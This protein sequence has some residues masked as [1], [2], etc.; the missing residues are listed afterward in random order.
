[1]EIYKQFGRVGPFRNMDRLSYKNDKNVTRTCGSE[2]CGYQ[3]EKKR[4][5]MFFMKNVYR[6]FFKQ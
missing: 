1:M 6:G 5:T 2:V 4:K 3:K